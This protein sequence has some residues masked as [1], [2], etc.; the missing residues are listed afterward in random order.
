[1]RLVLRILVV[2]AFAMASANTATAQNASGLLNTVDVQ[3]LVVADT[4]A[5][6]AALAK[7]FIALA[8]MYRAAAARYSAR[9]ASPGGNPNHPYGADAR[10]RRVRQATDASALERSVRDVA[11]YH[12]ILSIDGTWTRPVGAAAFDGGAGAPPPTRT[13]LDELAKVAR[14]S[15]AHRELVEYFLI[16]ARTESSN[17]EAYARTARMARVSG[18]RN[19]E[20]M[21]VRF[22]YLASTAREAARRANLAVELHRQLA[23]IG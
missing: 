23:E 7:H 3:R 12:L 18:A 19:T 11:A 22:E 14:T 17:A 9:A 1:M 8:A 10:Q 16:M 2:T 15:S 20:A 4:P 13:R 6:H 21:A 5:A